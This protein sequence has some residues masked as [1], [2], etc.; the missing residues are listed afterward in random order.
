MSSSVGCLLPQKAVWESQMF[1]AWSRVLPDLLS[2]LIN[3]YK[4]N[5]SVFTTDIVQTQRLGKA[6]RDS[7]LS[8]FSQEP[9]LLPNTH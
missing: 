4:R 2:G 3:N 5:N 6:L 7:K 9:I 1:I 8:V